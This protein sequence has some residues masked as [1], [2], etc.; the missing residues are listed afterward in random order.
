MKQNL[1]ANGKPLKEVGV[2]PRQVSLLEEAQAAYDK[3]LKLSWRLKKIG[4][5]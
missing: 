1:L 3:Y 5:N 4:N 2:G